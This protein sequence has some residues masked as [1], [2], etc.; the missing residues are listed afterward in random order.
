VVVLYTEGAN[1][2]RKHNLYC[3]AA[4][5]LFSVG[6][7]VS[8]HSDSEWGK[9]AEE[10]KWWLLHRAWITACGGDRSSLGFGRFVVSDHRGGGGEG[11]LDGRRLSHR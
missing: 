11:G 4:R 9:G 10:N 6:L 2:R 7:G 1:G 8:G 3:A 5:P